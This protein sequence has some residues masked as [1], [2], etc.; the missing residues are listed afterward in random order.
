MYLKHIL[1]VEPSVSLIR[2]KKADYERRGLS[3]K[4]IR[5]EIVGIFQQLSPQQYRGTEIL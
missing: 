4:E 3:E 1:I 5:E 2:E